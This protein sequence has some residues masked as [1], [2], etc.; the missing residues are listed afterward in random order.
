MSHKPTLAAILLALL[1]PLGLV[2]SAVAQQ[3]GAAV[4]V[5]AKASR[6]VVAPGDQ[7]VIAVVFEHAEGYHT[8]PNQPV[9]PPG[10]SLDPIPTTLGLAGKAPEGLAPHTDHIQWPKPAMVRTSGLTGRPIEI[11]SYHHTSIAYLP[12]TVKDDAAPGQVTLGLV[13][14]YQTCNDTTCLPPEDVPLE[15]PLTIA[16]AAAPAGPTDPEFAGFDPSVFAQIKAGA[17]P[18]SA[19]PKPA[20]FESAATPAV[21]GS[22]PVFDLFGLR[23]SVDSVVL[24]ILVAA[25][26]GFILNLTPCVLPVVPLKVMALQSSAGHDTGRRIMLGTAMSLGVVAF[27]FGLG[28]LIVS[29]K[30]FR[31]TN[32]LFGNPWFLLGVGGFILIMALGM[33]GAFVIRLPQKLYM[34]NP[35][36]DSLHGSFG[37]GVVTAILGTPCFGPFAGAAAG[38]ATTQP[39][40][41][42]LTAFTAIGVGMALPYMVLAIWPGLLG[43]VPRTGPAS[44]LVKQV[45]GLLLFAAG[46]FFLG[47][48]LMSLVAEKPH[49]ATVLHWWGVALFCTL[50]GLWLV[51]RTFQI[52]K[53]PQRRA[54][55][56]ALGLGVAALGVWWANWQTSIAKATYVPPA[57]H[58][59]GLYKAYTREAF[60][61]AIAAG[62]V[63]VVDFTAEWC[64]Q[65]KVMEATV[66]NRDDVKAALGSDG[67]VVFKADLTSRKAPGWDKLAEL[68][69]VGIPLLAIFGPGHEKPWKSNAYSP[70]Q[71]IEAIASARGPAPGQA[72][73]NPTA[74]ASPEVARR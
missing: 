20:S 69:E 23:F 21:A 61:K 24:I 17:A 49:L 36:H 70:G 11:Q 18:T 30:V 73:T 15:V 29:L 41:I 2:N 22:A 12:V 74:P 53:A 39:A 32:E 54:I 64:F 65:C 37:F 9:L 60:D 7:F 4:S 47:S 31:A 3:E 5:S 48:G 43:F 52:T 42:G 58:A 26:G 46:V 34:L 62:K 27:W 57:A 51:W 19:P 55:F 16:A 50:A 68:K 59:D 67:V 66:L 71:V 6:T 25:L 28:L 72:G 35:S 13:F 40:A 10:I 1:I 44:E 63:A 33:M 8:W 45:M 38:W 56:A 14:S